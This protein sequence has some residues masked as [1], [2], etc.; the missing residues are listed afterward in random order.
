MRGFPPLQLLLLSIVFGVLAVPMIQLTRP[1]V[2][3]VKA[4]TQA[5]VKS[6]EKKATVKVLVRVRFAHP[7]TSVSLIQEG[8]ELLAGV[9]KTHSP[10]E[11]S[12]EI[13]ATHEGEEFLLAASWPEGTPDTAITVEVEPDGADSQSRTLWS[14]EG[15][16][17][18]VLSFQW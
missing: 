16:L 15:Q 3:Q 9:E 18:E 1:F 7:P 5:E 17:S 6:G 4:A 2:P 14:N 11:V 13:H 10:L 12:S 8:K